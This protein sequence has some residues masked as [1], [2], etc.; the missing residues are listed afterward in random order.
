MLSEFDVSLEL[1]NEIRVDFL[2]TNSDPNEDIVHI[3]CPNKFIGYSV[4]KNWC[5]SDL[6]VKCVD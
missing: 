2:A 4:A 1:A 6:V 5:V 3:F